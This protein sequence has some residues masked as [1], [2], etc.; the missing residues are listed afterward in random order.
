LIAVPGWSRTHTLLGTLA[1][2]AT[3]VVALPPTVQLGN[4]GGII[5]LLNQQ[6][7]KVDGVAYTQEQA[8]KEGWTIVF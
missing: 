3:A 2:G 5:S 1:P 7:L 8:D 6:G 4:R